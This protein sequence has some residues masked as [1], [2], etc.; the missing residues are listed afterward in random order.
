MRV[1]E[2]QITE[3]YKEQNYNCA[4]C[5]CSL[6]NEA[7]NNEPF[8]VCEHTFTVSGDRAIASIVQYPHPM[9][10]CA[11]CRAFYN[12]QYYILDYIYGS[13]NVTMNSEGI[14]VRLVKIIDWIE[15]HTGKNF[16][17]DNSREN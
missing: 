3:V 13:H 6:R 15:D 17:K 11:E 7:W 4:D 16:Q 12:V 10:L 1:S 14:P 2:I 9:I 5:N 8:E